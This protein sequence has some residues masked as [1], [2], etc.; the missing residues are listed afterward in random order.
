[1]SLDLRHYSPD[2][3]LELKEDWP[4]LHHFG[5]KPDR[6]FWVS[7]EGGE[8]SWRDWCAETGFRPH[9]LVCE[10]KVNLKPTAKILYITNEAELRQFTKKYR[11]RTS[12]QNTPSSTWAI[13]WD[14]VA[15]TYQGIIITPYL[16]GCRLDS[17]TIWYYG[18]DCASGCIWDISAIESVKLMEAAK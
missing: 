3:I 8:P 13:D 9:A 18:W 10:H 16:W 4:P 12:P 17:A 15:V 5:T 2:P 11:D 6:G 1:M 14:L 7:V